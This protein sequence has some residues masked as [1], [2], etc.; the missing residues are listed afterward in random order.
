MRWMMTYVNSFFF[1]QWWWWLWYEWMGQP[2]VMWSEIYHALKSYEIWFKNKFSPLY[3]I[4]FILVVFWLKF[5]LSGKSCV[6]AVYYKKLQLMELGIE[7]IY[8]VNLCSLN[9]LWKTTIEAP[10]LHYYCVWYDKIIELVY[11]ASK[12]VQI[13]FFFLHIYHLYIN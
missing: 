12:V 1:F 8:E 13:V 7:L 5:G 3:F 11:K 10:I 2:M 6:N 4:R 9:I